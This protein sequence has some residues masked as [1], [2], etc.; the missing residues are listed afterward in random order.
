MAI[1]EVKSI[2]F[3]QREDIQKIFHVNKI[4]VFGSF[5]RNKQTK[6]AI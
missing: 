1:E 4:G 2:L 3:E 6:K 5:V